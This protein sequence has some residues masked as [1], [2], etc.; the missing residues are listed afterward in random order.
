[1]GS[2][3]YHP[4][5]RREDSKILIQAAV[6]SAFECSRLYRNNEGVQYHIFIRRTQ[7]GVGS[8]G[9]SESLILLYMYIKIT[10]HKARRFITFIDGT[11][12]YFFKCV[13]FRS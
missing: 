8:E 6:R 7:D 2:E 13:D 11:L 1:M 4:G 3:P 9:F 10:L 12:S 5:K